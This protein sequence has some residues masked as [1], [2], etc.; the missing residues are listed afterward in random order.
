MSRRGKERE[1]RRLAQAAA[2]FVPWGGC[3]AAYLCPSCALQIE[4]CS[5]QGNNTGLAYTE[6]FSGYQGGPYLKWI[7]HL[8]ISTGEHDAQ[9]QAAV[10]KAVTDASLLSMMESLIAADPR[11]ARCLAGLTGTVPADF[12]R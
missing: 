1:G 6:A 8:Q 2:G 9:L 11:I 3:Q 5:S 12:S 4:N 10:G 7:Q